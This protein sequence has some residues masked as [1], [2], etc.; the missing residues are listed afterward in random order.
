MSYLYLRPRE[1]SKTIPQTTS[2]D[3]TISIDESE[4][5]AYEHNQPDPRYSRDFDPSMKKYNRDRPYQNRRSNF[6]NLS[7]QQFS[8][9]FASSM[10]PTMASMAL[11]TKKGGAADRSD[12]A[13]TSTRLDEGN[14]SVQYLD[15][16]DQILKMMA[17]KVMF[18]ESKLMQRPAST[19][20]A[21]SGLSQA[22][23]QNDSYSKQKLWTQR[24]V[25][26]YKRLRKAE[27]FI[28]SMVSPQANA[29]SSNQKAKEF[30]ILPQLISK[31]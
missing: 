20:E 12:E 29:P 27:K 3:G 16:I 11:Q 22:A 23:E 7:N 5:H 14:A 28:S 31:D 17:H 8:S 1:A 18:L 19:W 15:S 13:S 9:S 4:I 26:D 24:M 21:P 2:A 6:S 25:M 10:S 30:Q